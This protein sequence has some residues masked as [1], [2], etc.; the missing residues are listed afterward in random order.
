LELIAQQ[1]KGGQLQLLL[2]ILPEVTGSYGMHIA[3]LVKYASPFIGFFYM[4]VTYLI[5]QEKLKGFA[6]LT[7]G[8]YLSVACQ[9]MLPDQTSNIW[10][11]L[12]SKST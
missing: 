10:K 4:Y 9:G 5:F 3:G 1:G 8:L 7:L 12:H 2:V 11:M 6:R